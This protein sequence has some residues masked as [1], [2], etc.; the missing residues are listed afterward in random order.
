MRQDDFMD[1]PASILALNGKLYFRSK[2]F[3]H[4][5]FILINPTTL[6]IEREEVEIEK[7]PFSL[8]WKKNEES[9]RY[10]THTPLFTDGKYIYVVS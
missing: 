2:K 10:L 6:E 4:K 3:K 5:P 1:V 8:E 9:G 7:G